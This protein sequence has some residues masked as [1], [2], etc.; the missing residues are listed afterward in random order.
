M[1]K[2]STS[3]LRQFPSLLRGLRLPQLQLVRMAGAGANFR[4]MADAL[5]VTQPAIT[6]MARE[7]ER[8]LGAPLFERGATGVRLSSFGRAVL[9]Q[10]QRSLAHLEQLVDDLP[11]HR[12]GSGAALRIGSPSFT[13]AA[14]LAR[15]VAQWLGCTPA[16]R[17]IMSDGVS[18]QLLSM[19]HAGE[20]DVVIGSLDDG[21]CSDDELQQLR[22]ESLYEDA[23]T[24]VTGADT[25]GLEGPLDL[26]DLCRLPWVLPP[27]NSLVWMTL[28]RELTL[29]GHGLPHGVVEASSIPAIG[30][31]LH[32][33]AGT[34]G[35]LRA[36]AGRYLIHHH[37]LRMLEVVP[38]MSL[39]RVG[40]MRLRSA[41]PEASLDALLAMV[42]TEVLR[43]FRSH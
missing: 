30:T 28:R 23:I 38:S 25:P 11:S 3:E 1:V 17:V 27:R 21:S 26:A 4:Q 40:I 32:H 15:P 16:G 43:M 42:R 5:H 13:A 19:L 31:I 41:P 29:H 18:A 39:P 14:L 34:V 22:F 36:D 35:A 37:G 2:S 10:V 33:A 24:F 12:E 9:S 8:T 6:K 20:L 7:L